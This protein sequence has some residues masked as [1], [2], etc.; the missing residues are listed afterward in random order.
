MVG[1]ETDVFCGRS[2]TD[3]VEATVI[4]RPARCHQHI[5]DDKVFGRQSSHLADCCSGKFRATMAIRTFATT[6]EDPHSF[7]RLAAESVLIAAGELVEGGLIGDQ[8]GLIEHQADAPVEREIGFHVSV[9]IC[10][11]AASGPPFGAE[12]FANKF[13]IPGCGIIEAETGSMSEGS[14][15]AVFPMNGLQSKWPERE[16]FAA[17]FGE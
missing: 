3:I 14:E 11:R 17:Y 4:K 15:D 7:F 9:A 2:N 8:R 1:S 5:F 16:H 13:R 10:G 6:E 12:R